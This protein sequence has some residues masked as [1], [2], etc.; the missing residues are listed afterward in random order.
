[1]AVLSDHYARLFQ[2]S[3]EPP[4]CPLLSAQLVRTQDLLD[5]SYRCIPQPGTPQFY[6]STH[7]GPQGR[8][9]VSRSLL[10]Q[11]LYHRVGRLQGP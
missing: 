1:M 6:R 11:S 4:Q 3:L 7:Q 8:W 9:Q 10:Y 5:L 2:Y